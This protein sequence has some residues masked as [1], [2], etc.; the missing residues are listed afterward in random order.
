MQD[1]FDVC[2]YLADPAQSDPDGDGIGSACSQCMTDLGYQG[3]GDLRLSVCGSAVSQS[4]PLGIRLRCGKPNAPFVLIASAS[5][6]L[7]PIFGG[8][9][10]P[11]PPIV[12][13]FGSL[14]ATG[15]FAATIPAPGSSVQA[16]LQ[17]MSSAPST[18]PQGVAISN[19]VVVFVHG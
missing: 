16:Y 12:T 19:A 17:A 6:M 15:E 2:P 10:I 18:T 9:L 7:A 14:G 3:P 8:T 5:P 11:A 4:Q 13:T 1:G